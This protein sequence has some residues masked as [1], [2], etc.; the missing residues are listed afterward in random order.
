MIFVTL[1]INYLKY[2]LFEVIQS[3]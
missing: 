1:F 3:L 2:I